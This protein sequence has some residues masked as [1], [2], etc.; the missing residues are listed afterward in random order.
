MDLFN[1]CVLEGE[2]FGLTFSTEDQKEG[3]RA[4]IEKR[5]A[6]FTGK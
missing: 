2:V 1:A 5:P 6:Q 4:F 3:M